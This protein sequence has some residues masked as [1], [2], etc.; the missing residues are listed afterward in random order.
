[1]ELTFEPLSKDNYTH[2]LQLFGDK[3]GC[4]NCWCMHF[5]LEKAEYEA[6]K[7]SDGNKKAMKKLVE[8]NKPT[9][10]LAF[11]NGL[12]IAWCAFSPR[13]DFVRLRKSRSP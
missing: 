13:E 11:H 3:G 6:G 9:G 4:A 10:L 5:R 1:M 2:F 12:A 8:E 7:S